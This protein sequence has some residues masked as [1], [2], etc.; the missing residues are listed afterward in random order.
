M[1]DVEVTIGRNAPK[2]KAIYKRK[3]G[4]V[5][6]LQVR[7]TGIIPM[8]LLVMIWHNGN[9]KIQHKHKKSTTMRPILSCYQLM[10]RALEYYS[11]LAAQASETVVFA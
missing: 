11:I 4:G 7:G 6:C 1:F 2:F 5:C 8:M 10:N 9:L 3:R